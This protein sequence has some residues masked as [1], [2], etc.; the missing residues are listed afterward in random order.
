MVLTPAA[1]PNS[2][3]SY[4]VYTV[5]NWLLIASFSCIWI[6]ADNIDSGIGKTHILQAP[7]CQ[8][9]PLLVEWCSAINYMEWHGM[10]K[11][12][13]DFLLHHNTSLCCLHNTVSVCILLYNSAFIWHCFGDI[14]ETLISRVKRES[15]GDEVEK[16]ARLW[17]LGIIQAFVI[18][19]PLFGH[20]V[21]GKL[22]S[23]NLGAPVRHNDRH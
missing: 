14:L 2:P 22:R 6:S 7:D 12:P 1:N 11:F 10:Q 23:P 16:K 18:C 5:T 17:L 3:C 19:F 13:D 21:S 15:Y 20:M 4:E 9:I 8:M